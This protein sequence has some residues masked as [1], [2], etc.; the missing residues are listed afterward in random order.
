MKKTIIDG[1]GLV[2]VVGLVKNLD[3]VGAVIKG[4]DKAGDVA[5]HA[6]EVVEVVEG[7]GDVAKYGD[8]VVSGANKGGGNPVEVEGKGSTGRVASKNLNEQMAMH[9]VQSNPLQ[10]ASEVPITMTDPRWLASEG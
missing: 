3:E 6:D 5:K 1:V 2:P 4:A 9:E 7:V 10:G 8:E